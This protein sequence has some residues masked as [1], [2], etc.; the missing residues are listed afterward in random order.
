MLIIV[1]IFVCNGN[2]CLPLAVTRIVIGNLIRHCVDNTAANLFFFF[3]PPNFPLIIFKKILMAVLLAM[4]VD[5]HIVESIS[6]M[7][8]YK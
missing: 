7:Q 3:I 4:M 6:R 5:S 8:P 1:V 2:D